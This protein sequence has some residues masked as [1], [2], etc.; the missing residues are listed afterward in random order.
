MK[1]LTFI[2]VDDESIFLKELS[3]KLSLYPFLEQQKLIDDPFE[4]LDIINKLKPDIVFLDFEMPGINGKDLLE[5]IDYAAQVIFI[6]SLIQPM[7]EVINHSGKANIQGYLSKPITNESLKPICLKLKSQQKDIKSSS[8]ILIPDGKKAEVLI[9]PE[10][11]SFIKADGKYT[12]W[13]FLNQ[14]PIRTIQFSIG[15]AEELFEQRQI[16]MNSANKSHL[17]F[18]EGIQKHNRHEITVQYFEDGKIKTTDI[19]I[20]KTSSFKTWLQGIFGS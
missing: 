19:A 9:K 11:L 18:E 7:Q 13:F 10:Q 1:K 2:A 4:A 15:K 14:E 6:S 17:V 16:K 3:E 12:N 8:K 5:K 20:G